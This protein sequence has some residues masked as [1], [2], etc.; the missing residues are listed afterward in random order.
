V[1]SRDDGQLKGDVVPESELAKSD[2]CNY[3]FRKSDDPSLDNEPSNVISP[4]GLIAH[5]VFNDSFAL[6]NS[7]GT[8]VALNE[9][10]IAWESDLRYKFKNSANGSTGQNFPAFAHW[11][12]KPC[13][14]LPT[15]E[16]RAKCAPTEATAGWCYEG[17]GYC[18]E[19]EHFVVWM[20]A[21]GL[22]SFRKLYARINQR[23]PVG[24]Y[25]VRVTNGIDGGNGGYVNA[26]MG[27][28]PQ[29]FLYPVKSF[30]GTKRV[31]LSTATWIGG[32]NLFLGYAYV[33][34]GVICIVLALCFLIK[35]RLSPRA[36][37][38][39]S[40]ISWQKDGQPKQA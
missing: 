40:Y 16:Q 22:P 35:Y 26:A 32:K 14:E 28:A 15:A 23:L 39:A 37:G 20:R 34:V 31:V 38:N 24:T 33:V 1:R 4:C 30:G 6:F 7:A 8:P 36:L 29:Q 17:S 12:Q 2:S 13:A 5:S 11:R 18:V 10:G 3:Y 27:G 9:T 21:A 19:D 25:T